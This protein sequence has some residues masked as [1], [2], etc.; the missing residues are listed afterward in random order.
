MK[1]VLCVIAYWG[2][3]STSDG[4]QVIV[5]DSLETIQAGLNSLEELDTLLVRQGLYE[6][7]LVA[8]SRRFTMLGEV[9]VDSG[10]TDLPWIVAT[11]VDTPDTIPILELPRGSSVKISNFNL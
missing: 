5:P 9:S 3:L 2:L 11:N 10:G 7:V 4:R 6:E 1:S 8:P